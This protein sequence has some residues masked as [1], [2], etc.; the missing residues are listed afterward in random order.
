M[1]LCFLVFMQM[2]G[3][4]DIYSPSDYLA[5]MRAARPKQPYAV[6]SLEYTFFKDFE[7]LNSNYSSI[8]PGK[9]AGDPVVTDI[10]ALRYETTGK[11]LFKLC[12]CND[13]TV[14]PCRRNITAF[15]QPKMLHNLALKIS[16]DKYNHLQDLKAVIPSEHHAF[17]DSLLH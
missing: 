15:C 8:R 2:F 3:N 4:A 7:K 9:R 13:W 6:H 5:L 10:R 16:A 14:L 1:I 11:V 17:Y 12:H